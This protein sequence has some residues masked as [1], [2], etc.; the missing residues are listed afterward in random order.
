MRTTAVIVTALAGLALAG[1]GG[2]AKDSTPGPPA[3]LVFAAP[4]TTT[5]TNPTTGQAMRCTYHGVSSGAYVP[6]PG[7]GVSGA[8]DGT[9]SS[10]II[11]LTRKT[12]G[13]LVVSCR[14]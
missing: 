10:A 12:D 2:G 1:C 4:T 3:P 11:N 7:H 13:S 14:G 8:A 9:S 6:S 5:I